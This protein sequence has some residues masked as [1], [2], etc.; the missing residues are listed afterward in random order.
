MSVD[1]SLIAANYHALRARVDELG[2]P[3][4][5]IV[6]V[7]KTFP[8][9]AVMAVRDAGC[10]RVGENY[11]QELIAKF[12]DVPAGLRPEI[13]FIGQLQSNKV[14]VL[15]PYVA[16]WQT[17][18]RPSLIES[19]AT[20]APGARV[21]IQVGVTGEPGKGGCAPTDVEALVGLAADR[22]LDVAGLMTVGPTDG[23]PATTRRVFRETAALAGQ[24]GLSELSM[25]MSG[26]WEIAVSEGATLIRVG[27]AIFGDRPPF[28][29]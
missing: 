3:A 15:A 4:V 1:A 10:D 8:I 20:R 5:G 23:D 19:L 21:M 17:V 29:R 14:R 2:G 22:G 6:A 28:V 13:H 16:V 25:G 9:E 12:S 18:D 26:D 11:A 24:L 27:S 7:T